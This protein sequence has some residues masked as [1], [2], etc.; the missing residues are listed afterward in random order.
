VG[1]F[2]RAIQ[3]NEVL[4][5]LSDFGAFWIMFLSKKSQLDLLKSQK[6]FQK[7]PKLFKTDHNK[8]AKCQKLSKS[9]F[10]QKSSSKLNSP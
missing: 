2:W 5:V 10:F 9:W 7:L 4:K 1:S 8:F 6:T 3:G